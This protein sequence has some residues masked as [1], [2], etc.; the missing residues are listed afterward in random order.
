MRAIHT[1]KYMEGKDKFTL[2]INET[3][4]KKVKVLSE[5]CF[6]VIEPGY[7]FGLYFYIDRLFHSAIR[8]TTHAEVIVYIDYST[9]KW[10]PTLSTWPCRVQVWHRSC[11]Q[12]FCR[13]YPEVKADAEFY[14]F[15]ITCF[16]NHAKHG[17]RKPCL[18]KLECEGDSMIGLCSKTY[19]LSKPKLYRS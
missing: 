5:D 17:K 2:E 7:I 18:L 4:F 16:S 14:W 1:M 11:D 9:A 12:S 13:D 6:E 3:R 8:Q 19:I 15:P 10:I